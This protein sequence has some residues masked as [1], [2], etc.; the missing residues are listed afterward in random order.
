MVLGDASESDTFSFLTGD[1]L[2]F[3]A[4]FGAH[5]SLPLSLRSG[6]FPVSGVPP[7]KLDAIAVSE[8]PL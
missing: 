8:V 3:L 2:V 7:G 6:S 1:F 4:F 5:N